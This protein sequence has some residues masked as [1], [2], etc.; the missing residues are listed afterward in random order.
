MFSWDIKRNTINKI[1]CNIEIF[2][3][4]I[5]D[6]PIYELSDSYCII[7]FENF[8]Q[9][10]R[11][12]KKIDLLTIS[13]REML[14]VFGI[15]DYEKNAA[16]SNYISELVLES[17]S[18]CYESIEDLKSKLYSI[19]RKINFKD[20]LFV[21]FP[22]DGEGILSESLIKMLLSNTF[23]IVLDNKIVDDTE[24]AKVLS[25]DATND[26]TYFRLEI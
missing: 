16:T 22:E 18:V 5:F 13:F 10:P 9:L 19:F 23:V 24:E 15:M 3:S 21:V 26:N 1:D 4:C 25:K 12:K 11:D 8:V 14:F 17:G 20:I 6:E 7:N 2:T